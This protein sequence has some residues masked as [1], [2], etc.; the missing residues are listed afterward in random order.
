MDLKG[1]ETGMLS[2]D[3][4]HSD[5]FM[6]RACMVVRSSKTGHPRGEPPPGTWVA[7]DDSAPFDGFFCTGDPEEVETF[8]FEGRACLLP[9]PEP[10]V[11]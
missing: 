5:S 9:V 4:E 10:G 6:A 7:P 2:G 11:T 1:D 3:A 8:S